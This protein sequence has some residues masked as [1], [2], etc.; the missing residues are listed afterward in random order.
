MLG[1]ESPGRP[2]WH[3]EER[4]PT[5]P[6]LDPRAYY[7]RGNISFDFDQFGARWRSPT[8]RPLGKR[9]GLFLGDSFTY[10]F[11]LRFEDTFAHLAEPPNL[12]LLNLSRQGA[13]VLES[14]KIFRASGL[15]PSVIF[16]G[17]NLNDLIGFPAS[18]VVTNPRK[19]SSRLAGFLA[20]EWDASAG[21][22]RRLREILDPAGFEKDFFRQNFA[23]LRR[24]N[25][26]KIPFRVVVLPTF[27]DLKKDRLRPL[28][29]GITQRL[30]AAGIKFI[31]ISDGWT[32]YE[33]RDLWITPYDQ[34]PNEIASRKIAER[35]RPF[36]SAFRE[37]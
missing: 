24:L 32:A 22:N 4:Y 15:R 6:E 27:V 13:D 9:F 37:E 28:Y 25:E 16:F 30:S 36:I 7:A 10:G 19:F 8:H 20:D 31:D 35:L 23:A 11:G 33:D 21:R 29:R 17:L 3:Y 12:P 34:H 1:L 14:E 18:Y 2:Y 26:G 5:S